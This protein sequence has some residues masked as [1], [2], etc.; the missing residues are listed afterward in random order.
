MAGSKTACVIGGTALLHLFSSNSYSRK[1]ML[2]RPPSEIQK[3]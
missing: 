1:D 3:T 2:S